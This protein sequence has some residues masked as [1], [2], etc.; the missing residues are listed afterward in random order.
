[1]LGED[2]KKNE[3]KDGKK[4]EEDEEKERTRP[5][6]TSFASDNGTG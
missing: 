2:E 5:G 1:L 6:S 4:D 3:K